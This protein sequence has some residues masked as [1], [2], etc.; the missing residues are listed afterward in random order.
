MNLLSSTCGLLIFNVQNSN[1]FK[2][3]A[4]D[5]QSNENQIFS[6]KEKLIG[7]QQQVPDGLKRDN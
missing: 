6:V 2:V 3:V 7:N 1:C 5:T 4:R